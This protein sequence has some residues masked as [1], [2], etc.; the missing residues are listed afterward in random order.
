ML[1]HPIQLS[2]I[3][4]KDIHARLQQPCSAEGTKC[5]PYHSRPGADENWK[6]RSGNSNCM[7]LKVENNH[8]PEFGLKI[9]YSA[10]FREANVLWIGC[11]VE[12]LHPE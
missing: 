8:T 5:Q 3:R 6:S 11:H 12:G 9:L 4:T 2:H 7:S 10:K 1:G